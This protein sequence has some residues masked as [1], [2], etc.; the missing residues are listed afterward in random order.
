MPSL[1]HQVVKTK[2]N[3][4]EI[5]KKKKKSPPKKQPNKQPKKKQ[6]QK[7][8][9]KPTTNSNKTTIKTPSPP[10]KKKIPAVVACSRVSD[11]KDVFI[12]IPQPAPCSPLSIPSRPN[13]LCH[14]S[15]A[16][17]RLAPMWPNICDHILPC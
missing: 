8:T 4:L 11:H 2:G 17:C 14:Y 12:I 1:L 6:P 7:K 5:K 16:D 9:N 3:L 10:S 13:G 15:Q